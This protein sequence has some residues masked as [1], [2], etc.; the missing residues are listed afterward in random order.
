M[1]KTWFDALEI[2]ADAQG[3]QPHVLRL[4][5]ARLLVTEHGARMLACELPD[6][7]HNLFFASDFS[8]K[9]GTRGTLTG[10][11][12]VW[13]SPEIGY[14]WPTLDDALRDPKG[15]ADTPAEIDPAA[16][17]DMQPGDEDRVELACGM[18]LTDMRGGA[19][20]KLL[21]QRE[22][23]AERSGTAELPG[24]A[25]ASFV[26]TNTVE[27]QEDADGGYCAGTWDILQVPAGGTLICPTTRPLDLTEDVRSYYDP[28]GDRHVS[29]DDARV[30]FRIDGRRR[31]KLGLRPEHTTGRMAYYRPLS[32]G[33]D[34]RA[35]LILRVFAPMPGEPYC[36]VPIT[37]PRNAQLLA[38]QARGPLL[39]GDC[40]QAYNDDGDAFGGGPDVTFGEMEYHDP[41][42]IGGEGPSKRTGTC[43]THVVAGPDATVRAWGEQ[44]LGCAIDPLT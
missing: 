1:P 38:G 27:L 13:I 20:G 44:T 14:F 10:G 42:V 5:D 39:G 8:N 37:D 15:T 16:W 35:S 34:A 18:S 40:L 28:F 23:I 25:A 9:D 31:V 30:R 26:V 22:I 19:S 17:H 32:H 3:Q 36:D 21:L 12:R 2:Q 43:V 6:V 33:D 7:D 29:V 24:L 41:C 11:D 4:G